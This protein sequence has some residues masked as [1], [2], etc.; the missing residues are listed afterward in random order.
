VHPCGLEADDHPWHQRGGRSVERRDLRKAEYGARTDA[1]C[2]VF[3]IAALV[4]LAVGAC[5]DIRDKFTDTTP[6]TV[7]SPQAGLVMNQ[8]APV[9][10]L[11]SEAGKAI[12][13]GK[14]ASVEARPNGQTGLRLAIDSSQ[15]HL[16]PANVLAKITA[17]TTV[18]LIVPAMPSPQRLRAGQL[19]QA[20]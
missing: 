11:G 14:V 3:A 16:I 17:P 10:L 20:Q 12:E 13:V 15:L 9:T 2:N 4:A 6:V 7:V 1:S 5:R 8:N 18:Q 19:I